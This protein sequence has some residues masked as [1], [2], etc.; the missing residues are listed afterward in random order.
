MKY[1]LPVGHAEMIIIEA[2]DKGN[3]INQSS[4]SVNNGA[5][6][7]HFHSILI[8]PNWKTKFIQ[9][10]FAVGGEEKA[11]LDIDRVE[12][13]YVKNKDN[14]KEDIQGNSRYYYGPNNELK[15]ILLTDG[16]IV[17]LEYNNNGALVKKRLI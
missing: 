9:I 4:R 3:I 14:W 13:Q 6:K 11:Y 8:E 5:W 10:R 17:S 15:Y 12:V 1:T 7:W 2:D 16:K